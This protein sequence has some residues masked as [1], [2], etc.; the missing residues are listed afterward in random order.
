MSTSGADAG[1]P[2]PDDDVTSASGKGVGPLA[3]ADRYD[4]YRA[5]SYLE[6][7]RD[8][9]DYRFPPQLGRVPPYQGLGL[10][11]KQEERTRRLLTESI[12]ISLHDHPTLI[13]E[14]PRELID[15]ERSG[16]ERLGYEGLACSGVTAF[17]DNFMD[18]TSCVTSLA[19]WK[20]TDIVADL[21]MRL[22]DIAQQD[23]VLHATCLDHIYEAHR[24]G[25]I[26]LVAAQE[27]STM[28]ENELDRIEIL[29]GFGVRLMGITYYH[30]DMLGSGLSETRDGGLTQFGRAAVRRMN[31]IGMAI[32][33]SHCGDVT[34]MEVIE[35]SSV[36][37]LITH[38][39][40]REVWPYSPLTPDSVT[41]ACVERGGLVGIVASPDLA[42]SPKRSRHDL[43]AVMDHFTHIAD[44]V[45]LENVG[46]GP[47]TMFGDTLALHEVFVED[48]IGR[49]PETS[50][51]YEE[52]PY[53][54]GQEN[55]AECFW[56]IVGWLVSHSYSDDEIRAVIGGNALRVLDQIWKK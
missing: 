22:C 20:W 19:G 56:N 23:F 35:L 9:K 6:A 32:D 27:A 18:G 28:I 17:F 13:P 11:Q 47:D 38:T 8:F 50:K 30:A 26:A 39:G 2:N 52:L 7:G 34:A 41:K 29:Y 49:H 16:R 53:V 3:P 45:G 10:T 24:T 37:V 43:H 31:Q 54:D 55:P 46:F 15:M 48:L 51:R 4:G 25:R 33:V 40:S 44:V 5:Y 21:G 42:L 36:P 12:V 14:D 1:S